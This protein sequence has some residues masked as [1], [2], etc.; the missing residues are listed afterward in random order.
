MQGH[1]RIRFFFELVVRDWQLRFVSI[2][3]KD[4]L[5]RSRENSYTKKNNSQGTAGDWWHNFHDFGV[6]WIAVLCLNTQVNV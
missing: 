5:G 4:E 1:V 3:W 6:G 2:A